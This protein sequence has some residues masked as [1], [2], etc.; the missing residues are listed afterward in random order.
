M[1]NIFETLNTIN[2]SGK[3]EKKEWPYIL[4]MGLCLG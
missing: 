2:V 1:E 3:T 4:V